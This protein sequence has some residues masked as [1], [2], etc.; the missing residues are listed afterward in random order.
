VLA[1]FLLIT[2]RIT[3][4]TTAAQCRSLPMS[5][6]GA[7][8]TAISGLTAQSAAFGNISDDVANSQTV[9]YKQVETSFVDYLTTSTAA[10]NDP[11]AVVAQPV[12]DNNVQGTITQSD[13]PLALAIAGQGFFAVSQST[14]QVNNVPTFNPQQYYTRAGDFQL[15]S[16]G[17]MVNSAGEY[18]NG[19]TVNQSTGIVNQNTLA[20]IQVTQ[21]VYNPVPTSSV[22]LSANLPATPATGTGTATSPISSDIDVYDALGTQHVVTL[23]WVQN[24]QGDWTV[25]ADSPDDTSGNPD[26]GSAE[27]Q[28]GSVSGNGVP[29][30]TVGQ[31]TNTTGTVTTAG[32]ASGTAATLNFTT[33]FG[34]GPQTISLN[35]GNYGST[36][37]V[38]QY[39]GTNYSLEGLTQ[40]GVPPG[41][42]SGVTTQA[43]GSII[44]NYNNGQTRNIAQVPVIT[45]N[46]ADAL[47]RQDGQS[48]T[49]TLGAGTPLAEAASTNGAGNLVTSS[50][51]SSNVDIATEFS[52]L[53]VAQQAY[54]A[55]AKMVTTAQQM[56]QTTVDMKQ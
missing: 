12:Y 47:Q 29:E 26:V 45:F 42:F 4:Q 52:N 36:G 16:S 48:F 24:S 33:N 22:D 5:L 18:L 56:L 13:N 15:N 46:N 38:T 51:E 44:V 27:V 54:S 10:V 43:N 21:T 32:Y 30:G 11:G 14:G 49:A 7:M 9:G 34:T 50:V 35:I 25:T 17:Y 19:W 8:N 20:P 53:I 40:N 1:W 31:I 41:S 37:G 23:N 28:F 6:L 3:A 55:N 39:A 2:S